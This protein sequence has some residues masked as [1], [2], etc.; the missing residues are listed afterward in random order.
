MFDKEEFKRKSEEWQQNNPNCTQDEIKN[1]YKIILNDE[2][3][4]DN[5]QMVD[6]IVNWYA[7]R[8]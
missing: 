1:C 5:K 2:D 7:T 3:Y 8:H 4:H 6:D